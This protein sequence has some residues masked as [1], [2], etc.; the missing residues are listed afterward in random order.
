MARDFR[1]EAGKPYEL[2]LNKRFTGAIA[3]DQVCL[4]VMKARCVESD[5]PDGRAKVTAAVQ[6]TKDYPASALW[7]DV[8]AGREWET[9][10]FAFTAN[11]EIP[12]GAGLL[13]VVLGNRRQVVEIADFQLYRFPAG[14]DFYSA[15]RMAATYEGREANAA[16]RRDAEERIAKV[17]RGTL[18]IRV[19]DAGDQPVPG[20]KVHVEMTRH[21]FGFGSAVDVEMLSGLDRT[22]SASDQ[23]KYRS[24]VDE[25][26]SRIVPEN[27]LRVGNID[28]LAMTA[29]GSA[30][31]RP[32]RIS[33]AISK[34]S[35]T[36]PL[37]MRRSARNFSV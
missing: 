28:Q 19:V 31:K 8:S 5:A 7:K 34:I 17:R 36:A 33:N 37:A 11:H 24:T 10:Y 32:P 15:P 27:G 20:A 22:I 13:K 2:A 29:R 18:G 6:N 23:I 16:W 35:P 3:K 12:E 1:G 14:F 9:I 25:L 4:F 21:A 30:F 26:F